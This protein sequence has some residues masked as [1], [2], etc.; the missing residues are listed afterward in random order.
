MS[1]VDMKPSRHLAYASVEPACADP[2][3]F[4][5][6]ALDQ[7][8][9]DPPL[10]LAPSSH[11]TMM[12][13]FAHPYFREMA[14]RRGP[15]EMDG[16]TLRLVHQEEVDFRVTIQYRHRVELASTNFLPEH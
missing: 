16:H 7:R 6:L 13:V 15:I 5:R 2:G 3:F 12:G 9:G 1:S 4:I 11:D 8:G 14:V 10:R